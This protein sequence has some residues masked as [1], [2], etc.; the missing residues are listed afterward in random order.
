M[1]WAT[2]WSAEG[3]SAANATAAEIR[4]RMTVFMGFNLLTRRAK[5]PRKKGNLRGVCPFFK[6]H[7]HIPPEGKHEQ[8]KHRND[9]DRA[10]FVWRGHGQDG[11][12]G[13]ARRAEDG[14]DRAADPRRAELWAGAS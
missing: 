10:G 9:R 5:Q 7:A 13:N 3:A 8:E 14:M 12:A 4:V 11:L 6:R 1:S 2:I